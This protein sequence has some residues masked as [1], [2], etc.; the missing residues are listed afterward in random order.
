MQKMLFPRFS[1]FVIDHFRNRQKNLLE[2]FIFI[3]HQH[4]T[5]KPSQ[6][7]FGRRA[8]IKATALATTGVSALTLTGFTSDSLKEESLL[9]IGPKK[10]TRRTSAHW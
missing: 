5:M 7:L 10:V 4:F 9:V 3:L 6:S 2:T 1:P 8:F